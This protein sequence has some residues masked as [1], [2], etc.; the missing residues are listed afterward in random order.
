MSAMF[1]VGGNIAMVTVNLQL[2]LTTQYFTL[3]KSTIAETIP[4]MQYSVLDVL[5]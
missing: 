4:I 2:M 1:T 3:L 5:A